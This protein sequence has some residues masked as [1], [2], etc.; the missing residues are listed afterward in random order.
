VVLVVLD[1]AGRV[2]GALPPYEVPQPW[3]MEVADVVAGARE[4]CGA[5]VT[6]LRL[7]QADRLRQPGGTLHYAVHL[8][9][10]PYGQ[11]PLSPVTDLIRARAEGD[12]PLAARQLATVTG[13]VGRGFTV[14]LTAGID[15]TTRPSAGGP[16]GP[17]GAPSGV[18]GGPGGPPRPTNS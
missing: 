2:L 9:P 11:S 3:W 6:V 8:D 12:H 4:N 16:G 10:P 17:D 14:A 18:P 5:E 15:P 7:L 13:D 1:E